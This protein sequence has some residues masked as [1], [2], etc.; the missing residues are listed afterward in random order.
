MKNIFSL[1]V[2]LVVAGT[3]FSQEGAKKS[4]DPVTDTAKSKKYISIGSDGIRFGKKTKKDG[5]YVTGDGGADSSHTAF[6]LQFG[7][8]DLGFNYLQDKTNYASAETQAF[9]NVNQDLKNENLFSLRE[10]KSINVNIYPVMLKYRMLK[11]K[12]QRI[13]LSTGVGLQI[14]N[15]RFNKSISYANDTRPMIVMDSISFKKNKVAISYLSIPLMINAKTKLAKD[16]W[17]TYGVGITGG[18]RIASWTKQIS[19]ERG[20]DKNHDAFNFNNFNSCITAEFGID[21][22]FRLYGSYQITALHE[23]SLQQY[24]VAIGVRFL[25]I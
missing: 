2:A 4:E 23:S 13:Y 10:G 16:L 14:Y 11:T 25:G 7:M 9:L 24:P 18:Y 8:L 5:I 19:D 3:A 15:F 6:E 20:K 21:G 17:L 12:H 1:I 22:Y